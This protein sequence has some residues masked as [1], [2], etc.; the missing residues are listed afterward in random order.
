MEA[1]SRSVTTLLESLTQDDSH[2]LSTEF[3]KI[4]NRQQAVKRTLTRLA[5]LSGTASAY[6]LQDGQKRNLPSFVM[7]YSQTATQFQTGLLHGIPAIMSS[8]EELSIDPYDPRAGDLLDKTW[9]VYESGEWVRPTLYDVVH[10]I[11]VSN[12][13]PK[14]EVD[15]GIFESDDLRPLAVFVKDAPPDAVYVGEM[16]NDEVA[17]IYDAHSSRN[18]SLPESIWSDIPGPLLKGPVFTSTFLVMQGSTVSV[19]TM[20]S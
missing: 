17:G 3:Y 8:P 7:L 14:L 4:P 13:V 6:R 18:T 10:W 20:F 1:V 9:H 12:E 15:F 19:Y 16:S 2:Q 11:A 5:Q